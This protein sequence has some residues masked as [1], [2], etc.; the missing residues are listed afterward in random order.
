MREL[1]NAHDCGECIPEF[2]QHPDH[3][4]EDAAIDVDFLVHT[5][6]EPA[7]ADYDGMFMEL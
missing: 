5:Q 6:L 1:G 7:A 3:D 2:C 4:L